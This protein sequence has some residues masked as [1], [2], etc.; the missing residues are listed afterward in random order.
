MKK[1][2]QTFALG[3]VLGGG[4][5]STAP[6]RAQ[7]IDWGSGAHSITGDSDVSTAGTL[8]NAFNL[9]A[10]GVTFTTVN[11][12]TFTA[13]TFPGFGSFS[14]TVA[15]GNYS[16]TEDSGVLNSYNNLGT[17]AGDY[18]LLSPSYRTLLSGGG[19]ATFLDTLQLTISG[20]TAG[21]T[22]QFQWWNNNSSL[23]T[24]SGD[25]YQLNTVAT[26]GSPVSLDANVGNVSGGLGQFAIGTFTADGPTALINFNGNVADPSDPMLNAFQ[27]RDITGVPEPATWTLLGLGVLALVFKWRAAR[28]IA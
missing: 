22:Y 21:Q 4:L 13:F 16:F 9:G 12:V 11:G 28:L 8:V 2:L 20:L 23:T 14:T 15:S 6:L 19:S 24:S 10:D 1:N 3:L 17:V 27:L 25:G 7:T 18:S 26:A 5:L